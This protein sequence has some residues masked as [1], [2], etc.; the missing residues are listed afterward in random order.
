MIDL[1]I[2]ACGVYDRFG[3][4]L[5]VSEQP[6]R[7]LSLSV[8]PLL[9]KGDNVSRLFPANSVSTGLAA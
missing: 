5:S 9:L 8:L 7:D 6:L 3:A 4:E 1:R 2:K